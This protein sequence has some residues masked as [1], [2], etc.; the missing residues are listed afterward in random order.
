MTD[1]LQK[2]TRI[3][4]LDILR[5]L[6]IVVMALDHTRDYY[7]DFSKYGDATDLSKVPAF[8]FITRWVTHYCAPGFIFLAG[9]SAF[10]AGKRRTKNQLSTFLLTRGLWLIFVELFI[11]NLAWRLNPSYGHFTFGVLWCIG[12]CMVLLAGII[13][14]PY[15]AIL[16]F[17]LVV[18]FLHNLLDG[19]SIDGASK[20]VQYLWSILHQK[21]FFGPYNEGS[22]SVLYPIIPWIGLMSV[23]YCFGKLYTDFERKE[24]H[25]WLV[26]IGLGSIA[27]FFFFRL[28]AFY[29][30]PKVL[31]QHGRGGL[32]DFLE[33]LNCTKYPPSLCYLLMTI[34]PLLLTLWLFEK[35]R[36]R[37]KPLIVF[38]RV[39][40]FF[41]IIHIFVIHLSAF[42]V[43]HYY[44][45]SDW[46]TSKFGLIPGGFGFGLLGVYIAWISIV[47]F[48]Y[49]P[50]YF[51]N[52][53]KRNHPEKVWLSYF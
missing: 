4:S 1:S 22:I 18:V 5:G 34:G 37:L 17:G 26:I 3:A 46:S 53:Y 16:T 23:G 43:A 52:R 35:I 33:V 31:V 51:F 13:R 45:E 30:E 6:I 15:Y 41:Y 28:T 27:L 39:P 49:I 11:I 50:C 21:N 48:L 25:K 8:L 42:V 19:V 10:L 2:K 44:P 36:L 7:Y 29:G 20:P 40:F 38:G 47:A 9:T 24:R 32:Y 12:L 14:L